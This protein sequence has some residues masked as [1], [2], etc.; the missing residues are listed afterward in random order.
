MFQRGSAG[1]LVHDRLEAERRKQDAWR[2]KSQEGG[3]KGAKA[4][5]G[6]KNAEKRR[7]NATPTP[8]TEK[9]VPLPIDG[10]PQ[11]LGCSQN[12]ND[13]SMTLQFSSSDF[14][15]NPSADADKTG[16]KKSRQRNPVI[17]AL[18][19]LTCSNLAEVTDWSRHAKALQLIQAVTPGV[20]AEEIG[21]RAA[22]YRRE[23]PDWAL[24]S[25]AL[26]TH[27]GECGNGSNGNGVK[28]ADIYTEP[29]GWR[30]K[31]ARLHPDVPCPATWNEMPST[32]RNDLVFR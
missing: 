15:N 6:N 3:Y 5:W 31:W 11:E 21:R 14:C 19:S 25:T 12:G 1:R 13:H 30:E 18:A 10:Q 23:H 9:Q 7:R 26:A 29:E 28:S 22:K 32:H 2:E 8:T 17:D 4:R 27:W 24:T 16:K 20:T